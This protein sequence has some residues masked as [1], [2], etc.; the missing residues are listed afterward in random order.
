MP[1]AEFLKIN[2]INLANVTSL[3]VKSWKNELDI[4]FS[5]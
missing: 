5:V 4:Y 3:V 1:T 2:R